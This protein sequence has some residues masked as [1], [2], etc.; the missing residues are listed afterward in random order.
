MGV[1]ERTLRFCKLL[2]SVPKPQALA[3][4]AAYGRIYFAHTP[5]NGSMLI[6]SMTLSGDDRRV[7]RDT[8]LGHVKALAVH[9]PSDTLYWADEI[10][11]RIERLHLNS[12]HR[13]RVSLALLIYSF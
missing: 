10:L 7:E 6:E 1:C 8:K 12:G 3:I 11:E 4:H 5:M 9:E 13:R 2:I